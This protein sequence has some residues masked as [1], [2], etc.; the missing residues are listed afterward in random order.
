VNV[1]LTFLTANLFFSPL[2]N[3][4][5]QSSILPYL[6]LSRC[7]DFAGGLERAVLGNKSFRQR[8]KPWLLIVCTE[9][10]SGGA[11]QYEKC[12]GGS[13]TSR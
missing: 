5:S 2:H 12:G 8:L 13:G 10:R 7:A 6:M 4:S 3:S 1:G 9:F 11:M